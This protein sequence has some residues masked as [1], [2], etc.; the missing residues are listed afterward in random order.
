MYG[1]RG[2]SLSGGQKQRLALARALI[3]APKYWF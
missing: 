3:T 2:G 1:E